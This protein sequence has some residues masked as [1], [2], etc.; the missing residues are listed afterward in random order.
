MPQERTTGTSPGTAVTAL[1]A[2]GA[3]ALGITLL[4][5]ALVAW[6]IAGGTLGEE[7]AGRA[8]AIG[9]V[10]GCLI[11]GQYANSSIRSRA[12]L[13]GLGVGGLF[14][15]LWLGA[16]LLFPESGTGSGLASLAAGALAGGA[17]SGLLSAFHKKRRK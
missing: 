1:L 13:V 10:L 16:G 6:L 14:L 11:G 5:M 12:L 4:L 9:A 7:W 15:L 2:G 17:V 3:I 8:G